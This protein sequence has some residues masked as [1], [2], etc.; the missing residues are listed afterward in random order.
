MHA[1]VHGLTAFIRM[2]AHR[3]RAHFNSVGYCYV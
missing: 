3:A 2:S 1:S